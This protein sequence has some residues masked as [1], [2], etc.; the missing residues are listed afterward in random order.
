MINVEL[1]SPPQ[2]VSPEAWA[3]H[4]QL[5]LRRAKQVTPV[6]TGRLQA[7]W[8]LDGNS[9]RNDV[10]YAEFV[11]DGTPRLEPRRMTQQA[12]K[13]LRGENAL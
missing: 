6:R 10:P 9:L 3:R 5:I 1:P 4:L 12:M 2:G 7:G 8:Y 11:N 13:L